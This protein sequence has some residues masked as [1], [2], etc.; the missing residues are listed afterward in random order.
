MK[1]LVE[2][3]KMIESGT[4]LTA[5]NLTSEEQKWYEMLKAVSE[6]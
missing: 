4:P 1:Q 6:V 2:L 5:L 3:K